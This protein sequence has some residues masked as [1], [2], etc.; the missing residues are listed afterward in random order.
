MHIVKNIRRVIAVMAAIGAI[1]FGLTTVAQAATA[2]PAGLTS[3]SPRDNCGG[4]NGNVSWKQNP[5]THS[6]SINISGELWNNDCP[7]ILGARTYLFVSYTL[8]PGGPHEFFSI[9]SA[10]YSKRGNFSIDWNNS[11]SN[12]NFSGIELRVCNDSHADDCGAPQ[13]V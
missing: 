10:T 7:G 12:Q 2:V 5:L 11:K 6:G 13:G 8:V 4:F 1:S 9:G 3:V